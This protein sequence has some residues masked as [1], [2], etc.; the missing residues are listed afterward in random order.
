M[1]TNLV[2]AAKRELVQVLVDGRKFSVDGNLNLAQ[3]VITVNAGE[4]IATQ[5]VSKRAGEI[6]ILYK[7]SPFKVK[8]LPEQVVEFLK[9]MKE[10]PK[11]DM[12]KI[13]KM[14]IC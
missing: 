11:V 8:V 5:I 4:K 1:I 2:L 14:F 3:P 9:H 6:T 10:R 7:G 13:L 12:Q